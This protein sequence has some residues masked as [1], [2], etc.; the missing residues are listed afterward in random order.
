MCV[1]NCPCVVDAS[2]MVNNRHVTCEI[3][4]LTNEALARGSLVVDTQ[5][6]KPASFESCLRP[7]SLADR[8]F[9]LGTLEISW[10]C[11]NFWFPSA[12][13]S[14]HH[15]RLNSRISLCGR[16]CDCICQAPSGWKTARL[17]SPFEAVYCRWSVVA[18]LAVF[19][20]H[21]LLLS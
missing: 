1:W 8:C 7:Q 6:P 2:S 5:T 19:A 11:I 4:S 9:W 15:H 10:W 20:G 3:D 13:K 14:I 17:S 18:E 16:G 21:C 12:P